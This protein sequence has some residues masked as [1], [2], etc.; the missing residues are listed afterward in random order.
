MT[1]EVDGGVVEEE[2][3]ALGVFDVAV[4]RRVHHAHALV[5]DELGLLHEL[6]VIERF[7][8]QGVDLLG[9]ALGVVDADELR[10]V[11]R[12]RVRLRHRHRRRL[13]IYVDRRCVEFEDPR[14][15]VPTSTSNPIGS[16]SKSTW[17]KSLHSPGSMTIT[18]APVSMAIDWLS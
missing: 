10:E 16:M 9:H 4:D 15:P 17:A 13:R 6:L 3:A 1:A 2:E 12:C 8:L 11:G 18:S 7:V 14:I 5:V